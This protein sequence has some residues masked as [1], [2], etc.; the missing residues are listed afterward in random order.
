MSGIGGIVYQVPHIQD[1]SILQHGDNF[2]TAL[3]ALQEHTTVVELQPNERLY[4]DGESSDIERG[5]FFIEIG[6]MVSSS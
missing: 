1:F 6:V 3:L 5:L 2:S 4:S